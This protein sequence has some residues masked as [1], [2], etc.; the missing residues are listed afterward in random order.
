MSDIIAYAPWLL[1]L[2]SGMADAFLRNFITFPG[3]RLHQFILTAAG[4]LLALPY[5]ILGLWWAGMP[6]IR[7]QF[8]FFA[9][10]EIPLLVW[11][12][13]LTVRAHKSAPITLVVPLHA[14]LPAVLLATSWLMKGRVPTRWGVAG[15]L[16]LTTGLYMLNLVS[17]E[18]RIRWFDPFLRVF[19]EPGLRCMLG[20]IGLYS[21]TSNLDYG[22]WQSANTPFFLLVVHGACGLI[23]FLLAFWYARTGRMGHEEA[24]VRGLLPMLALYGAVMMLSVVPQITAFSWIAV[25][26]YVI[27]EKRTGA[28]LF[29]VGMGLAIS[30]LPRYAERHKEEREYLRYRIPGT[31]IMIGGMIL[32]ILW[33][34]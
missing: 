19:R 3:R 25:V 34:S 12:Q 4:Y 22:A 29:A 24:D 27:A 16:I 8:W 2:I 30:L 17:K 13:I 23:S 20:A 6:E 28:I 32:I 31:F 14:I 18:K 10:I 5:Y 15:V 11:A 1:P 9:G 26:P 33:G 7:P 21:I